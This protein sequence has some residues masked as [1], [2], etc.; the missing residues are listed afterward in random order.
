MCA[1]LMSIEHPPQNNL[2]HG[3]SIV[4]PAAGFLD[5]A[6]PL[7]GASHYDVVAYSVET[8]WRK[9]ECIATLA[10]GRHVKLRD[11]WQFIGYTGRNPLRFLLF[12]DGGLH[13]E[14]RVGANSPIVAVGKKDQF[15]TLNDS[16]RRM[17]E[18]LID[19]DRIPTTALND[20]RTYTTVD[21]NQVTLPKLRSYSRNN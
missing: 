17:Q 13:I 11:A 21:G 16:S 20:G 4:N 12:H 15:E 8:I 14:V 6:I 9:A 10:G 7:N 19:Y 3:R 5:T 2:I 18:T 1:G